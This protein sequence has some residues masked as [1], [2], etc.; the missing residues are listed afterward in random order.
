MLFRSL[1]AVAASL[2]QAA[3]DVSFSAEERDWYWTLV[4]YFNSLREL[5]SAVV[6]MQDDVPVT[7]QNIA[8]RRAEEPRPIQ[9]PDELTS[10]RKSTEIRD[11]LAQLGNRAGEP[12]ALPGRAHRTSAG[13]RS[14]RPGPCGR[15]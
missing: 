3:A 7:I 14:S 1:Q 2:L 6:L 11:M 12:A 5:G 9:P 4:A 8:A 10:R 13:C 15:R